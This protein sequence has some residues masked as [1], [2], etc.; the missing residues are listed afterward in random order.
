MKIGV[1]IGSIAAGVF[2]ILLCV[3]YASFIC[4]DKLSNANTQAMK[5]AKILRELENLLGRVADFESN[6]RALLITQ[7]ARFLEREHNADDEVNDSLAVLKQLTEN[8]TARAAIVMELS[9]L[10]SEKV[11]FMKELSTTMRSSGQQQALVMFKTDRGRILMDQIRSAV[12]KSVSAEEELLA[13]QV[14][15]AKQLAEST[16]IAIAAGGI[17]AFVFVSIFSYIIALGIVQATQKLIRATERVSEGRY[18]PV[19]GIVSRDE[20]GELAQSFN[21]MC[22]TLRR[23]FEKLESD[24][25]ASQGSER[26]V[27]LARMR[28]I[29]FGAIV[30]DLSS[31][32][33]ELSVGLMEQPQEVAETIGRSS[34]LAELLAS[35]KD[36]LKAMSEFL[37]DSDSLGRSGH[38]ILE[39]VDHYVKRL[40]IESEASAERIKRVIEKVQELD[41]TS[42]GIDDLANRLNLIALNSVSEAPQK[43]LAPELK[44]ISDYARQESVRVKHA[45]ASMDRF[46][47]RAAMENDESLDAV[48]HAAKI[49]GQLDDK[50]D[51][52]LVP[53]R[54]AR[55]QTTDLEDRFLKLSSQISDVHHSLERI[56]LSLEQKLFFMKQ[57]K[58]T[59]GEV[60][61]F[62]SELNEL[63]NNGSGK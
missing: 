24:L 21:S 63:L 45:I 54:D 6:G 1:K 53:L 39:E 8:D 44:S 48:K 27:E 52:L 18:E 15:S 2:F 19:I 37:A 60:S 26:V 30:N 10:V 38:R 41:A 56:N 22:Q 46:I 57:I 9:H 34:N 51:A 43:N 61:C 36:R 3:G 5:T 59:A 28:A 29:S 42:A 31:A 47:N 35:I 50:L 23:S 25:D 40:V 49:I 32:T 16:N 13:K 4:V 17:L 20:L 33:D 14:D 12:A 58:T 62:G 11:G 7:D 55:G